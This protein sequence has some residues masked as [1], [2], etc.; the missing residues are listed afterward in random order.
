MGHLIAYFGNEPENT[1]CALFSAR[2]ALFSKNLERG[3]G[4]ALG[5]VQG[6]DVLL[7]ERPRAEE[8]EVDLYALARGLKAEA[9][10]ARV[11]LSPGASAA[12][13]AGPFRFRSWLFGSV[14]TIPSFPLIRDRMLEA[15]PGFLRRNLRG[16]S[17][18][19]HLFHIFL[20][21]LHD[22][23]VLDQPSPDPKRVET[24]LHGT[25]A[26]TSR[27]I[28][29]AQAAAG[30]G[31]GGAAGTLTLSGGLTLNN[32]AVLNL[33]LA[34]TATSD[35]LAVSGTFAASGTTTINLTAL[36]NFAGSGTYPLITGASGISAGSFTVGATPP[37]YV[38]TLGASSGT[39]N[40]TVRTVQENWRLTYFGTTANSGNAADTADPDGDGLTNAQ[41]FAAGTVPNDPASAL[42]ASIAISGSNLV[43]SFPTVSG[44]SYRVERSDT[45]ANG[46]WTTLSD[47]IAG[48]GGVLQVTDVGAASQPKRFYRVVL[49]P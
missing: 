44:K 41:E 29:E 27:L 4:W 47:N 42:R 11:G 37:G 40:L 46:S 36:G 28:A 8:K 31:G 19:E 49:L 13:N 1:A 9:I 21:Y 35:K 3:D 5:F 18:A 34:G 26:F 16:T 45:L 22:A 39:L 14:G 25:L 2:N 17:A 43:V 33:D 32:G 12:E 24:A 15:V 38:G 7:Q 20:A 6:G 30:N 48:T 10:V 23:G